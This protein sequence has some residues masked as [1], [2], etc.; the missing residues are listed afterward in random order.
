[1]NLPIVQAGDPVL[2]G[3]ARALSAEEI[4]GAEIQQFIAD[5]RE[6]MR[7]A[8]GVGLAAP[9]VGRALQLA[10]IEDRS[11]YHEKLSA[12]Q[13]AARERAPV[14]FY[15]LVNPEIVWRTEE[16]ATFFEGC[17]SLGGFC[18]LV[19]RAVQVG[20]RYLDAAGVPRTLEAKGWHARIIQH[21]VDHLQGTLYIDRMLSRT[22]TSVENLAQHWKDLAAEDMIRRLR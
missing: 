19:P 5:M 8:P 21:E 11:E 4:R 7:S 1:L 14:E 6:T 13:M 16:N 22:F 9:Q 18:A 20:V 10:V 3:R 15:A 17:L 12:E 2:R